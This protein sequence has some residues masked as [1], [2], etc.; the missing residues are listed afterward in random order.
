MQWQLEIFDR[1]DFNEWRW[2]AG[3]VGLRHDLLQMGIQYAI[4]R[5]GKDATPV[6]IMRSATVDEA[7]PPNQLH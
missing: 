2:T 5:L 4:D 3:A 1:D 7:S 6:E